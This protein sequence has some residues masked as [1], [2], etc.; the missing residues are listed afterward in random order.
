MHGESWRCRK[1][2]SAS[3]Y[4]ESLVLTIETKRTARREAVENV[5]VMTPGS[6]LNP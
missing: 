1:Y 4:A 2:Y 3:G 6:V 5:L